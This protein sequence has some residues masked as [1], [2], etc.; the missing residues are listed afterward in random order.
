MN[1]RHRPRYSSPQQ[2]VSTN[3]VRLPAAETSNSARG[4]T[5]LGGQIVDDGQ[6]YLAPETSIRPQARPAQVRP[7][8]RPAPVRP[9]P[10]PAPVRPQMR[11]ETGGGE[12]G[13]A[14]PTATKSASSAL[15]VTDTPHLDWD[16]HP[17]ASLLSVRPDDAFGP[18]LPHQV[19]QDEFDASAEVY[20]SVAS[21]SGNLMI[22]DEEDPVSRQG[23][24]SDLATLMTTRQGRELMADLATD[25]DGKDHKM[26]MADSQRR[27]EAG[28]ATILGDEKDAYNGVGTHA[29]VI[30]SPSVMQDFRR[31]SLT[32]EPWAEMDSATHLFHE[33]VHGYRTHHG[34][35][36]QGLVGE[37]STSRWDGGRAAVEEYETVGLA[38]MGGTY[39]E[40]AFR[41]ER[42]LVTGEHVPQRTSYMG[43]TP[44]DRMK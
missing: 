44:R 13:T 24:L 20:D 43:D 21:G 36:A 12:V 6:S 32:D 10:R 18:N 37:E 23:I 11:P 31:G 27:E 30:Y 14:E 33:M 1:K 17:L 9:I 34:I 2:S 25:R 5:L 15:S 19:W 8:P 28:W 42:E 39:T 22:H 26:L 4:L 38:G 40:N 3:P 29:G 41:R 16:V 7:V 35:R